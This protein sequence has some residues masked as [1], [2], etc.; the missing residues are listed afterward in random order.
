[1]LRPPGLRLDAHLVGTSRAQR[2]LDLIGARFSVHGGSKI[3]R[4]QKAGSELARTPARE[5]ETRTVRRAK[6][7]PGERECAR[8]WEDWP[9]SEP[10]HGLLRE[11]MSKKKSGNWH[12]VAGQN[13]W[14]ER[15]RDRTGCS[16]R[17]SSREP[18]AAS[19]PERRFMQK[20]LAPNLDNQVRTK[21]KQNQWQDIG[22]TCD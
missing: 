8:E 10:G 17:T 11:K 16:K 21:E 18:E 19:K 1:V 6:A 20:S 14:L 15:A 9:R 2:A 3:R 5:P 22:K 7:R 12:R 4:I 13:R